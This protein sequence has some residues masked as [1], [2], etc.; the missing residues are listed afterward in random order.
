L[1]PFKYAK[2]SLTN[3]QTWGTPPRTTSTILLQIGLLFCPCPASPPPREAELWAYSQQALHCRQLFS[4]AGQR[5]LRSALESAWRLRW[6]WGPQTQGPS[7]SMFTSRQFPVLVA[8]VL[9]E[10]KNYPMRQRESLLSWELDTVICALHCQRALMTT[11]Q[12]TC[13]LTLAAMH[14]S[15]MHVFLQATLALSR[16]LP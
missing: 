15:A 4:I 9:R 5:C 1:L 11:V 7:H 8:Q 3:F 6:C 10:A 16:G 2:P 13:P 12:L 14:E